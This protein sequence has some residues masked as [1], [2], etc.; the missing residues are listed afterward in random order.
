MATD[1]HPS[2]TQDESPL[3]VDWSM[4]DFFNAI[5]VL[6]VCKNLDPTA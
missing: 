5:K 3:I 4:A 2:A 6:S 1:N